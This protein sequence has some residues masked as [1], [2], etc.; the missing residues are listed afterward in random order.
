MSI[1][2]QTAVKTVPA[3][4]SGGNNKNLGY[5]RGIARLAMSVEILSTAA[6]MYV[7]AILKCLQWVTQGYGGCRYWIGNFNATSY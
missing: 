6:W 5:R 2:K 1:N 7:N 3:A 4:T